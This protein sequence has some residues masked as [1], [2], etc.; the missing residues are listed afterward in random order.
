MAGIE[1]TIAAFSEIGNLSVD[2]IGIVKAGGFKLASLPKLLDALNQINQLIKD[3]PAALPELQDLDMAEAAQ[4][5]AAAFDLVKKV[6]GAVS[7]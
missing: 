2:A 5:G 6:I 4:V 1:K 7:A 3:A